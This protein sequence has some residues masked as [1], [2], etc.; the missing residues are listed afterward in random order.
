MA[1]NDKPI[2]LPTLPFPPREYDETYLAKLVG[3]LEYLTKAL[4]EPRLLLGTGI[5]LVAVPTS[6]AGLRSGEVYSDSGTLKVV[7]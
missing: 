3:R 1:A 6:D 7:P 2:I 4:N 5:V